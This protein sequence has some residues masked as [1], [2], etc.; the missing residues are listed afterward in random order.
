M[1]LYRNLIIYHYICV[2]IPFALQT[3][4]SLRLWSFG[5]ALFRLCHFLHVF[6][7]AIFVPNKITLYLLCVCV[8]MQT[9]SLLIRGFIFF[10]IQLILF[11]KPEKV[12]KK[13]EC[14]NADN[15]SLY[16]YPCP[17]SL[18]FFFHNKLKHS[19]VPTQISE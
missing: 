8:I 1:L 4:F 11:Q 12:V 18:A 14:I 7:F 13:N 6:L 16:S 17:A 2:Q 19:K 3:F 15:N 5:W 10:H 9:V